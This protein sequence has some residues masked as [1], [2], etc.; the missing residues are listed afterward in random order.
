VIED[1]KEKYL[2]AETRAES[3]ESKCALLTDTNLELSEELSF[4]RG[5]V[6]R[7]ENSLHEANQLKVS[8]A[9]DIASKTKT[10]MDL[11]AKLSLERERLHVQVRMFLFRIGYGITL[12]FSAV[13]RCM[14]VIWML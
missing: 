11:V 12:F 6:E 14:Y 7:L 13:Y 2:K 3:A 10:I 8:S 4:L 9:K 5:R 1:M